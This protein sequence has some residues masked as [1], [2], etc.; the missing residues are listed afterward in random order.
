[1][2][3]TRPPFEFDSGSHECLWHHPGRRVTLA[4]TTPSGTRNRAGGTSLVT[5]F[6]GDNLIGHFSAHFR[7]VSLAFAV[8]LCV[9][10]T[11]LFILLYGSPNPK[12]GIADDSLFVVRIH[13]LL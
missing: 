1:M 9:F 7:R 10:S 3:K 2:F 13:R 6:Q 5:V 4:S 12:F 8:I 11:A